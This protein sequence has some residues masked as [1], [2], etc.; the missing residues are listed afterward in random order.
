M[1]CLFAGYGVRADVVYSVRTNDTIEKVASRYS[2]TPEQILKVNPK[3]KH[4]GFKP[5]MVIVVP[6]SPDKD[7]VLSA[8]QEKEILA[9][10][11]QDIPQPKAVDLSEVSRS[12]DR[13]RGQLAYRGGMGINGRLINSAHKYLGTPYV[14]GGTGNGSFDCS[15]FTMRM[16]QM[17]GV[18]LPRTADVQYGVGSK[19]PFGEEMPGDLVF[20]ETYLPGPSHVGIYIGEGKFIHASSS[21]GVTISSLS[22]PYYS[23]RYLGAKRVFKEAL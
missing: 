9:K 5:G 11:E 1:F 19:V 6:N 8:A 17:Y 21:R 7:T 14:M 22:Q 2:V 12:G 20:F 13:Y 18:N 3:L 23:A 16:F 4:A 15:G 10:L